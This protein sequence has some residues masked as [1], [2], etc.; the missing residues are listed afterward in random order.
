MD[1]PHP[2][3]AARLSLAQIVVEAVLGGKLRLARGAALEPRVRGQH[4]RR[5][6]DDDEVAV[7]VEDPPRNRVGKALP[8]ARPHRSLRLRTT[9]VRLARAVARRLHSR[10]SP[11]CDGG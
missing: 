4:P 6:V 7:L 10:K 5:L 9:I 11:N 3:A 2:K 1:K 8:A